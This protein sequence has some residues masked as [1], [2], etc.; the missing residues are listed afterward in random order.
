[1]Q[2]NNMLET[3]RVIYVKLVQVFF[4]FAYLKALCHSDVN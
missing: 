2:A 4:F 1:M 3:V